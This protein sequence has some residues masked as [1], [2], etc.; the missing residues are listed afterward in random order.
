MVLL[1]S[2]RADGGAQIRKVI[3]R[4]E[5]VDLQATRTAVLGLQEDWRGKFAGDRRLADTF[6]TVDQDP[7]RQLCGELANIGEVHL[8]SS[9][10]SWPKMRSSAAP[11]AVAGL[12]SA[13]RSSAWRSVSSEQPNCSARLA[14]TPRSRTHALRWLPAL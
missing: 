6:R 11:S 2:K 4:T 3:D 7:R 14:T 1:G 5:T 9:H 8:T 12:P 10:L 13:L